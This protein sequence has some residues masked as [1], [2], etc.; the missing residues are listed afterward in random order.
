[1]G[2]EAKEKQLEIRRIKAERD[3][4]T[5]KQALIAAEAILE[6]QLTVQK[7]KAEGQLMIFRAQAAGTDVAVTTATQV[8]KAQSSIGAFTA[9]LGPFG[10]AAFAASIGFI[11]ASIVSARKKANAQIAALTGAS[12]GGGE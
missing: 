1:M 11:I 3:Q 6:A 8:A 2:T 4:F 9:A 12:V 5:I 7:L 10:I